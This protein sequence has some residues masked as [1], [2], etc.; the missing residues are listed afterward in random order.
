MISHDDH[1]SA[2]GRNDYELPERLQALSEVDLGKQSRPIINSE[3][4]QNRRRIDQD[5]SQKLWG[6]LWAP[7]PGDTPRKDGEGGYQAIL[8][9]CH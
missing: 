9:S 7:P 2:G 1:V 4:A 5:S 8:P 6:N 3:S